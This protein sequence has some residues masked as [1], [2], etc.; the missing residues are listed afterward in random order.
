MIDSGQAVKSVAQSLGV[1]ESALH[2]WRRDRRAGNIETNGAGTHE[3]D[4]E[5]QTLRAELRQTQMERDILK[6]ALSIFSR[7]T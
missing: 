7:Q 6:K 5:I 4:R 2:R 1:C 3:R